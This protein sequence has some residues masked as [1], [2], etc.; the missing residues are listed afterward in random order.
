MFDAKWRQ[1][2]I[3][4]SFFSIISIGGL[5]MKVVVSDQ[6]TGKAYMAANEKELFV[7]K[8]IGEIIKLD[9]LGLPGYEAKITG[10][11]DKQGF[12]MNV[13]V[14]GAIRK[15]IFT[16]EASGFKATKKGEKKRISV[17]GNTVS[18]ET[19]QLNTIITKVGSVDI[20]QVLAKAAPSGEET[21]SAKERAVKKSLEMAGSA[22]IGDAVKKKAR[23]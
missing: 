12:P 11:S 8:K 20:S 3:N 19:A 2:C 15:K 14:Q 5:E 23:H 10:G 4:P 6:K 17:R 1:G 16:G 18:N 22:E 21:M 13:S 7:G 9:E